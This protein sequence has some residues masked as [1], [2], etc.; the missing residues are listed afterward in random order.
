MINLIPLQKVLSAIAVLY[1]IAIIALIAFFNISGFGSISIAFRGAFVLELI[2]LAFVVFGW[3]WLWKKYPLLNQWIYPDLNGEWKVSIHWN[4]GSEKGS[5]D[6][7]AY[8]KQDFFRL[9]MELVS[10]ES[11][12]ETL[13]VKP[14]KDPESS[15][16]IL[17][18]IYRNESVQGA[19]KP[20]PPH[21]G[22][23]ILKLD[24]NDRN[25]LKGNYFTDRA[26]NG[27]FELQRSKKI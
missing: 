27:H 8:I 18:Y 2:V 20:Q 11:E 15:R 5:K 16:P 17:Y 12:S 23:A 24:L 19:E 25:A 22:A 21:T 26:T 4:R 6:A 7:T 14:K 9:S 10:N 13:M 1:A 3:R